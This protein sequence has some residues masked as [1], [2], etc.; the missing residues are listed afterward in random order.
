MGQDTG[1]KMK[2]EKA[3]LFL[4]LV[5]EMKLGTRNRISGEKKDVGDYNWTTF[6]AGQLFISNY[7]HITLWNVITYPCPNFEDACRR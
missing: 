1:G 5:W 4:S 3:S 2:S 6:G 7:I